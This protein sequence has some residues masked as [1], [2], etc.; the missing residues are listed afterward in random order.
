M[1]DPKHSKLA[2]WL[3]A[4][5]CLGA[6][7]T[8]IFDA[9]PIAAREIANPRM[10]TTAAGVQVPDILIF[11]SYLLSFMSAFFATALG[12]SQFVG[13]TGRIVSHLGQ[14][15]LP[16][17][18]S[19]NSLTLALFCLTY[20]TMNHSGF[21]S[22][23]AVFIVLGLVGHF[24]GGAWTFKHADPLARTVI[25]EALCWIGIFALVGVATLAVL[26]L[27]NVA[28]LPLP[29]IIGIAWPLFYVVGYAISAMRNGFHV[30]LDESFKR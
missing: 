7:Y 3:I 6:T 30:S 19:L 24:A 5:G 29:L 17:S 4:I 27:S 28:L 8:L 23:S 2:K 11:F 21:S 14:A 15:A 9:L 16:V 22:V 1:F 13:T 12:G 10:T 18:C 20:W 25:I 26:Q